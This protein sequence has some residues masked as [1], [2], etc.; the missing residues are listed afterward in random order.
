MSQI[1]LFGGGM[2][3]FIQGVKSTCFVMN[4]FLFNLGGGTNSTLV[5]VLVSDFWWYFFGQICSSNAKEISQKK[6][7]LVLRQV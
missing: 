7:G 2:N 5:E 3:L 4:D 6:E 1:Q